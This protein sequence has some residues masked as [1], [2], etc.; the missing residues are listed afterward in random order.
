M[1][2]QQS[3][4]KARPAAATSTEAGVLFVH[5]PQL[6]QYN[7]GP[8][9]P[10]RPRRHLLLMDLLEQ[11]GILQHDGPDILLQ[12]EASRAELLLVHSP[13][14]IA[15]VE[16]FSAEDEGLDSL[17]GT[18]VIDPELFGFGMGDNP[19]F[20]GMHAASA[21]IVGGTLAAARAVMSGKARHVFNAAGGFHHALRDRASG[22]C[23]YNDAAVAIAAMLQEYEAR[24]MYIDFDAHH[25]DG[26]QWA[27]YDE[28]DVMTVSFHETGRYLFPGTGDLLELGK[29]AG[30]GY[31][32][33]I[34][35]DAY[36][37]DDSWLEAVTAL[38][39][40]LVHAFHPDLIISQHGC[41]THA[42]DPLTHL[43][44]TTR[45]AAAQARLTRDLAQEHCQGRWVAL[46]GGGYDMYRVVPR[47]WALVWSEMSGRPLPERIPAAWLER[48]QPES[49]ETL[50]TTFLDNPDD[51]PPRPR[52]A[53][54]ERHN[55]RVVAQARRLF[56]PTQ[57]RH[58]YPHAQ[59]GS[60]PAVRPETPGAGVP[61]MLRRAGKVTEPRVR[62]LETE[63][64]PILLRDW[65]PP[66]LVERL[67]PDEG[68]KA[69]ARRADREQALL[70]RIASS[71]AS[72]LVVAHTPEGLLIG[73]VS[74][75][76]ADDWWEGIPD[77]YE[78][79]IEI[80]AE[81][82]KLG[83]SKAL[84]QFALEP[85]YFEEVI[86]YA[87]GFAWHWDLEGL[88]IGSTSYAQIIR[89]LFESVGF[90]KMAASEPNLH[91][92]PANIF[93]ARIGKNVSPETVAQFRARLNA[94]LEYH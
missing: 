68:L 48:W 61:D 84:L 45:A 21:R 8:N 43:S 37:E 77:L 91:M 31:A 83:L 22:F 69:F 80:S 52:R 65:C 57:V 14:Y 46:G 2:D 49:K 30:R 28:P 55:R 15:A 36:T 73:Q 12:Q 11:S 20:V 79:A 13:A 70:K 25:G 51:F 87:L 88:G 54:I 76:T 35:L 26:V 5:D 44:L 40:S 81:W 42:W 53:E 23:I 16:R 60:F 1:S 33:N 17:V 82:R 47:A 74:I 92:D 67:H 29:G 86:L 39:P 72:E 63:R 64:G 56:L 94:P 4:Q 7:F 66:S 18:Y 59:E 19:I 75:C 78:V 50:P 6:R 3:A 9:H 89:R 85:D 32:V 24:I 58:A 93:L 62:T 10:L 90:E 71:P 41:D 34:P 27:F 38:L